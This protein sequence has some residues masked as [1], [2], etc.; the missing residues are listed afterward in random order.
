MKLKTPRMSCPS[1]MFYLS[2][3]LLALWTLR[4]DGR[5][6]SLKQDAECFENTT[7]IITDEMDVNSSLPSASCISLD[8]A[9]WMLESDDKLFLSSGVYTLYNFSTQVVREISN[10]AI[11]GDSANPKSVTITCA[12]GVGLFFFNVTTLTISGLTIEGCGITGPERVD[13]IVNMTREIINFK[14]IPTQDFSTAVFMVHCMD[15]EL[16]DVVIRD[17]RGFGFVGINLIGNTTF[18]R[19]KIMENYPSQCV[20]DLNKFPMIGGSGGGAFFIYRNYVRALRDQFHGS[21]AAL[22][23][24]ESNV[25]DNFICRLNLFHVLHDKLPKSVSPKS[26]SS[27]LLGAGGVSLSM[28]QSDFQVRAF[29]DSCI[30][31]NNSGT[32]NGA[33]MYVSQFERAD[34]SHV[35]VERSIFEENGGHLI[36]QYGGKGVGQTGALHIWFYAPDPSDYNN[37]HNARRLLSQEP[38]SV[39]VSQ[40]SFVRNQARSGGGI[41]VVSFGPEVGV[42]QDLLVISDTL[43]EHNQADFGGAVY[44]SELSYSGFE[45]GLKVH[46]HNINASRNLKMDASA[47]NSVQSESGIIEINFL[48]VSVTG[49]NYFGHN[50]DTAVSLYSAI[51]TVSGS[52]LMEYNT[53]FT[54]GAVDMTRESYLILMGSTNMTFY[55]NKAIIAGGAVHVNFDPTRFNNYDCFVFDGDPDFFCNLF[56]RC[57]DAPFFANFIE[58]SAPWG[59]AIY[60][61]TFTNCP[62]A[63]GFDD[64]G[65]PTLR[66]GA[67]GRILSLEPFTNI[68]PNITGNT[69]NI[70]N[71]IARTITPREESLEFTA[72]PGTPLNADLGAF[73]QL[74]QPVPLTVF[75]QLRLVGGNVSNSKATAS[76]GATNRYLLD[77]Q[78]D[79]FTTVPFRVYG[80]EDSVYRLIITSDEAQVEL[81]INVT[82]VNCSLGFFYDN[83]SHSCACLIENDI[84]DVRCE[85][86]GS[87]TS[88]SG[89][90]I[91]FIDGHGFATARCEFDYCREDVTRIYLND[92]DSQCEN[93]RAGILCGRC[94]DGFSRVLG[95]PNCRECENYSLVIIIAFAILG[96]VLVVMVALFNITITD[97]YIN[98]PIFYCNIISLYLNSTILPIKVQKSRFVINA[99][100]LH[101]GI[102]SCFYDG[103]TDLHLSVLCLLFPFYLQAI[104][105]MITAIS[106]YC[107]NRHFAKLLSK[108]NITHVFATLLL[109]SYTSIFRAC[110]DI[111]SFTNI[112]VPDGNLQLWRIDPNEPYLHGLHLF[113]FF[114]ALVLM[115]ILLPLPFLLISTVSFRL[116]YVS[117]LKPLIDAFV[118]PLANGKH[119]WVGFRIF[120]RIY[121][122]LLILMEEKRRNI[123]ICVFMFLLTVLGAYTKPFKTAGR[124]LVDL[125]VMV[126]LT[127]FTFMMVVIHAGP[128]VASTATDFAFMLL[129]FFTAFSV[130]LLLFYVIKAFPCASR[131]WERVDAFAK[132]KLPWLRSQDIENASTSMELETVGRKDSRDIDITHTSLSMGNLHV[133]RPKDEDFSSTSFV[134]Y[135]ESIFEPL[136]QQSALHSRTVVNH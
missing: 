45:L 56:D 85:N 100:N 2:L 43:F 95:T 29:F 49:D 109:L 83:E 59:S 75:S 17:N 48:N 53:G 112:R 36:K 3:Q 136:P 90:W 19:V 125:F 121:F 76:I 126:N 134:R 105:L 111:L 33:A 135:R 13:E 119:G 34:N 47:G 79:N 89:P 118:A 96:I 98:G 62:W 68:Y 117:R 116:P 23:F 60:G 108:V 5:I 42:I 51:V 63:E 24:T 88:L 103:M 67:I 91:G 35:Y 115:V 8:E 133:N 113:E 16:T 32:Y 28:A 122:F 65:K 55:R 74:D 50:N 57:V 97:G 27:S 94:K 25:T 106:K 131:A 10:V 110:I 82:F 61:S 39:V 102:E 127:I 124:N 38:S 130:S 11:L 26:L 123:T 6:I 20:L 71:T 64:S 99:V 128:P 114:V 66:D 31:R 30:F 132:D 84:D 18:S 69:T 104:L 4:S 92:S 81:S 87:I 12:Q 46:F 120:C 22:H 80:E 77:G 129:V 14:Y 15:S 37:V 101:W 73:D 21:S 70:F 7:G 58:N 72:M 93:N 41:S 44:L 54:G 107:H 52:V 40:S 86:D 1:S 9:L 78:T